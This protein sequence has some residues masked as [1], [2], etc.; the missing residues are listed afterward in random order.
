MDTVPQAQTTFS[1]EANPILPEP[2]ITTVPTNSEF[3]TP[4]ATTPSAGLKS[5]SE[6][7]IVT[8]SASNQPE[9]KSTAIDTTV[10]QQA[11][12]STEVRL[13]S[14]E[15]V[16]TIVPQ[17]PG[18]SPT[19]STD[20]STG[21]KVLAIST[22]QSPIRKGKPNIA[23]LE[24]TGS[25]KVFTREEIQSITNRFETEL[26]KTDSFTVLERRNMDAIL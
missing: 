21:V 14:P 11:K 3:P 12:P 13:V 5:T 25:Y 8:D 4:G 7:S 22:S 17:S 23:V 20:Q 18:P 10:Q 16:V 6:S 15:P 9:T 1:T 2:I 26:M 24:F 19:V